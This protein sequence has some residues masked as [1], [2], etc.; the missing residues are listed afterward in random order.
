MQKKQQIR[1]ENQRRAQIR[2]VRRSIRPEANHFLVPSR[3]SGL[4][5]HLDRCKAYGDRTV[6]S[7]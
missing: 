6:Q 4:T 1:H 2:H 3:S 5:F 7:S